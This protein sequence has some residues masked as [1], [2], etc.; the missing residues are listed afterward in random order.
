MKIPRFTTILTNFQ[1]SAQNKVLE[2]LS[3]LMKSETLP[4][5]TAKII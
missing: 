2:P 5:D 4:A 1:L 3:V